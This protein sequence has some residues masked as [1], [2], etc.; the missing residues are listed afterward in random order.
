MSTMLLA[1][2]HV[3]EIVANEIRVALVFLPKRK[4]ILKTIK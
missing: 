4:L 2:R 1:V 3:F